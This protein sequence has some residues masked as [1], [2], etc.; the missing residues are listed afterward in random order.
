MEQK[1]A[2]LA[3]CQAEPHVQ[4]TAYIAVSNAISNCRTEPRMQLS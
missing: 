2:Q 3:R 1:S 4:R